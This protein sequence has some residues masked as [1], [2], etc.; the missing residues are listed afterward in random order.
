MASEPVDYAWVETSHDPRLDALAISVVTPIRS[1]PIAVLEPRESL[2]TLTVGQTL[3]RSLE[4]GG[5][6]IVEVQ[7]DAVGDWTVLVEPNG[8]LTAYGDVLSRL[9]QGGKAGSVFWNVN[10]HMSFGWAVD[11]TLIRWFD[12]LL[13]DADGALPEEADLPFGH[14]GHPQAAALALLTRLTGVIVDQSWLL[15]RARP[16]FVVPVGGWGG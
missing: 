1:E 2:G 7:V 10:A 13:Y 11:G 4:L 15:D 3:D 14:P 12:P 5:W 6:D 8:W 16:T 9:S